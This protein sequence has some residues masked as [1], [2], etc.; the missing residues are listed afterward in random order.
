MLSRILRGLNSLLQ[1]Q[2]FSL[3]AMIMYSLVMKKMYHQQ[4]LMF[5]HKRQFMRESIVKEG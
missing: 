4:D 2:L 1:E 3:E 5:G